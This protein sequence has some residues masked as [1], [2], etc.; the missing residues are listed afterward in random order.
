MESFPANW[1]ALNT[2]GCCKSNGR[3]AGGGGLAR[4]SNGKWVNRFTYSIGSRSTV[5][6]ELWV[7]LGKYELNMYFRER[8]KAADF[9]ANEA[10]RFE[11]GIRVLSSP[12]LES[13]ICWSCL[14]SETSS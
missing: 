9:L 5:E 2:D 4:D 14:A 8:N 1:V 3:Y 12:P 6:A 11:H 10:L 7:C 13:W